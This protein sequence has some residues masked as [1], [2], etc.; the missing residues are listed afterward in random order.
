MFKYVF[1]ISTTAIA[2]GLDHQPQP[3]IHK[4]PTQSKEAEL[5]PTLE[6]DAKFSSNNGTRDSLRPTE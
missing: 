2:T 1:D 4:L 5:A 3:F 6:E